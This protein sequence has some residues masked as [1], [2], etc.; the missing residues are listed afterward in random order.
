MNVHVEV[1][2]RFL[3][4]EVTTVL[5]RMSSAFPVRMDRMP[6]LPNR[7]PVKRAQP[8]SNVQIQH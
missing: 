8:D 6:M 7:L 1:T 5:A 2:R 4:F 3:A